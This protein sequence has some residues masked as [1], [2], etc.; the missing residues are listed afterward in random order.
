MNRLENAQPFPQ[1]VVPAV[2]GGKLTL[3]D[4]LAGKWATILV[5]RGSWCPYCAAQLAA[6]SRAS[7]SFTE[8]NIAVVALSVD[9]EATSAGTIAKHRIDFPVG[10]SADAHAVSELLGTY[11]G[12]NGDGP[13][14][15]S[16]GFVLRPDGTVAVAVYSSDAIGRLTPPDVLGYIKYHSGQG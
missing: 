8:E 15:Q 11:L 7:A 12:D 1:L 5:Y 2:G 6:F 9:D 3:P 16:T 14:L 10:H 13:F 4:D